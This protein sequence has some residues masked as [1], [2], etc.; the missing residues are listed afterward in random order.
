MTKPDRSAEVARF[1]MQGDCGPDPR[2]LVFGIW[3]CF[4]DASGDEIKRG[5]EIA[6]EI[7]EADLTQEEGQ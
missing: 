1:I 4:H 3:R 5:M 7:F 2:Q 6:L